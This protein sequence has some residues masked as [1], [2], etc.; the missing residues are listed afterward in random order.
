[1]AKQEELGSLIVRVGL[2]GAGFDAGIKNINARM[3]LARSELKASASQFEN[4]GRTIDTLRI[5]QENLAKQYQ[6]QSKRVQQLK[7]KYDQLVK[8]RGAESDAALR[9]GARL[10]YAI[11]T[12]NRMG[13]QLDSLTKE[14]QYQ[15][16]VWHRAEQSISSFANRAQ[17]AGG[18]LQNIGQRLTSGVSAPLA[19]LGGIALKSA[20]DFQRSQGQMQASLGVTEAEAK[21][22]NQSA[23]NIWKQGFG[24]SMKDAS[25]GI[26][27]VRKNLQNISGKQLEDVTRK[28]FVLKETF[29]YEI[30]ESTR[31]AKALIDNF[32]VD[33]GK[34]FDYITVAAQKGGDYS[35]ELLDT[36]SEYSVQ[37]KSAGLSID[38][39]FNILIQGAQNGGWSMDKVADAVKEFHIR[40]QDGSKTTAEGFAMI[41]LDANKMGE[42]IAKG[43]EEGQR[44]FMATVAALAAM[45]DPLKQNQAGVALFGTQWEDVREKVITAM[46]PT[47]N[48]LGDVA[49]A[50][51]K[52]GKALQNNLGARATKD[53]RALGAALI[54]LG[55]VLLN[56]IEPAFEGAS[57]HIKEFAEWMENLSPGAR[58]LVVAI[59][60]AAAAFGPL[61]IGLGAVIRG[62]GT[63]S[64]ALSKGIGWFGRYRVEAALT[65]KSIATLGTTATITEAKM[66]TANA[67]MG[68][69][70]KG[71]S[72]LRGSAVIAGGA[73][74]MFGGKWG[75]LAGIA[76]TFLPE[77]VSAG[78][79]VLT[80]GK[81]ATVSAG[82]IGGLAGKV[83]G[84]AKNFASFSRILGVARL[85][86]GA[87]GGPVGLTITGVTLLAQGGYKL[88]KTLKEQSIPAL[89]S[90]GKNVSDSTTKAILG[91]K[92]LNDQ[93]TAQLNQ[94]Y[95]SG[96]TISK[97]TAN[98][99]TNTFSQMGNQISQ[100]LKTNFNKDYQ[101][102][103]AFLKNSKNLSKKEQQQILS[104]MQN[105]YTQQQNTVAKYE[106]QIK[107]IMA[108]ASNQK[109]ALTQS[110][111]NQINQIQQKMMQVAVQTMSKGEKE[112][113]AILLTLKSQSGNITAQQAAETVRNS[114][115]ARNGAIKAAKD[116]FNKVK[117]AIIR[118]RDETGSISAQQAQKLIREAE[119]QRDQSIKNA[120]DMHRKVVTAAHK[121]AKGQ[122]DEI[123][124]GTGQ[125]LTKWDKMVRG[126]AK[127]VNKMID[128]LNWVLSHIGLKKHKIDYWKPKGL[129]IKGYAKGT[130][131]SGHP[132]GPAIVGEKGREL[133]HIPGAGITMV[134]TRGPELIPNLPKGSSILPNKHTE[135]LLK[136]YGFPGYEDGVGDFFKWALKGPKELMENVWKKFNPSIPDLGGTFSL[137]GKG[138]LSFLKDKSFSFIKDKLQDFFSFGNI[139]AGKG[140]VKQWIATAMAITGVPAKYLNALYALAMH[141]SGGN[142]RAINLW[143]S[144]YKAGHPSKGLMQTIDSTF[145]R[146]KLPGMD[147]IWNPVHN[148]V[149]AIRYMLDRYGSIMNVPGIRNLARGKGYVGYAKGTPSSGHPGGPAIVGEEGEE[150]GYIPG[151]GFVLLGLKGPML[152][153]LPKGT[154]ILPH[155]FTEPLLR[156]YGFPAYADGVGDFPVI[157]A[158]DALSRKTESQTVDKLTTVLDKLT[159][160][161]SGSGE[162]TD[163]TY[164]I[165][166]RSI[167]DGREVAKA[168]AK[169]TDEELRRNKLNRNRALGKVSLNG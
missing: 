77:I 165:E 104:D 51:D 109:R 4:F 73:L 17:G 123:N 6:L 93:A 131:S 140:N 83:L 72:A 25:Q 22:M 152:L 99:L 19:T 139:G 36:I 53:L 49:G 161:L 92:K 150:L 74:T 50:T 91:Y 168:T 160:I 143:D 145:N 85:G 105:K 108:K 111:K 81:N 151:K 84:T 82:G 2:D 42:A 103:S 27:E 31:A 169:Y 98:Q 120:E 88:Y 33:A 58:K 167:I 163:S 44:A 127:G 101:I 26:I 18:T 60:L 40:A 112:Q 28:A 7:N 158:V 106:N 55:N 118:E 148:A 80:F 135:R 141:E 56:D 48:V 90:F 16:S 100:S 59:G 134:G 132:G 62:V 57:E 79:H 149:A 69:T 70:S 142:P 47:K 34:A 125:V 154:S 156:S 96:T 67:T 30:P 107:A 137:M 29:G 63:V 10:N 155:K 119:R 14:V 39:M 9:A 13:K 38:Q 97:Q 32:G 102:I 87:L 117:S 21:R 133:A 15:S 68:K 110:E 41:G 8:A 114:I 138:I 11:A 12:Y 75:M 71:M 5:K 61:A 1:M 45:K 52:A 126:V 64:G 164:V 157:P 146:Y 162:K 65:N 166:V 3:A 116:K 54:P 66:A 95:W 147:D 43:G 136:S 23:M 94:L 130:P 128:G 159:R 35:Q 20:I 78:K 122:A 115:K 129:D 86:L 144:N 76:T 153:N 89:T 24:E 113:R 37:F 121:Q 46:D 124:W